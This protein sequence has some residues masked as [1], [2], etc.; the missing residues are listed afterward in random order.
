MAYPYDRQGLSDLALGWEQ[1]VAPALNRK[2]QEAIDVV[3]ALGAMQEIGGMSP[4]ELRQAGILGT[5]YRGARAGIEP[6][7]SGLED[8]AAVAGLA[9]SELLGAGKSALFGE[10]G[11]QIEAAASAQPARRSVPAPGDSPSVASLPS[12]S[13]VT[14]GPQEEGSQGVE[15]KT[16]IVSRKDPSGRIV[17]ETQRVPVSAPVDSGV[18]AWRKQALSENP[19]RAAR[20][21][22]LGA[23]NPSGQPSQ[24]FLVRGGEG[25]FSPSRQIPLGKTWEE[26]AASESP[27]VQDMWLEQKQKGMAVEAANAPLQEAAIRRRIL[28]QQAKRLEDP[29]IEVKERMALGE[30][31]LPQGQQRRV[32]AVEAWVQQRLTLLRSMGQPA[33]PE[34]EAGLRVAAEQAKDIPSAQD[35]AQQLVDYYLSTNPAV[36][37]ARQRGSIYNF[38]G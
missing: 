38:G 7:I 36:N 8:A 3:P 32:Q 31:F 6:T 13:F 22:Q 37:A 34:I 19:E 30:Q 1:M 16:A 11:A 29:S 25:A 14:M 23:V 28:E 4:E 18:A 35:F 27:L 17:F 10:G 9:G 5:L 15:M 26:V 24:G 20:T 33:G 21:R 2:A 12:P